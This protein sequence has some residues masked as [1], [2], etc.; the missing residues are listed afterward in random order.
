[1]PDT[2]M[3][4]LSEYLDGAMDRSEREALEAHLTQCPE[5][6][7]VLADLKRVRAKARELDETPVPKEIWSRIER[8]IA[9]ETVRITRPRRGGSSFS[10]PQLLAACLA[11]AI[12][13]GG[14]VFAVLHRQPARV[15][16]PSP[17]VASAP[18]TPSPRNEVPA[19]VPAERTPE[20]STVNAMPAARTEAP[21]VM[22]E[23][24]TET[25]NE[26]AIS[27]LRKVLA[28]KRD[29]LDP[30]TIR[31]LETNLA[32]I[33]LAIDQAKRALVADSENT[34]VKEH[35]AETMR[36]KVELLQ[37]ATMLASTSESEGSR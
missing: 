5:C 31:T 11:V 23:A 37:R 24:R 25:P 17:A 3:E 30:A 2:W 16:N 21:A 22:A 15:V 8:S 14:A 18:V 32:I 1:M 12:V 19:G 13:S 9:P 27:E 4:R 26:E 7:A 36:R 34:Y 6:P 10:L 28:R 35:L 33:D 20:P 29:Q